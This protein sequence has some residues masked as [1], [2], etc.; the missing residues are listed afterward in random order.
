[1]GVKQVFWLKVVLSGDRGDM[2]RLGTFFLMNWARDLFGLSFGE[3]ALVL[4]SL[5]E[6]APNFN[7][8]FRYVISVD[9]LGFS[10]I[11]VTCGIKTPVSWLNLCTFLR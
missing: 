8:L 11:L 5:S 4:N 7:L 6:K 10:F 1:M 9:Y 3:G 2:G